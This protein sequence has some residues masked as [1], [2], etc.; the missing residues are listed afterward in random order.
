MLDQPGLFDGRA[1]VKDS[2]TTD[3]KPEPVGATED[4]VNWDE[5]R[6]E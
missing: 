1:P 5:L 2:L 3:E 4:I 6:R